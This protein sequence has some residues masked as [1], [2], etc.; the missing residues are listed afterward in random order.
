MIR[1]FEGAVVLPGRVLENGLTAVDGGRI[2]GVWDLETTPRPETQDPRNTTKVEKGFIAPG[3]IDQHCH[4]AG[5]AD[6]MDADPEAAAVITEIHA[7]HG[8]TAMLATTWTAPEEKIIRAIRAAK[9]APR[10]GARIVG[11]HVE[12]PFINAK[13][14][15]AQDERFIRPATVAE[16]DRILTEGA[17]EHAWHFTVA[18]EIPGNLDVVRY[19]VQRGAVVS[20]G[21]TDCTY[22]QLAEAAEAGVSHVT[23][24]YNAMRGLHHREPGTVG[25]AITMPAMTVELIADGIHVHP[26][27]MRVAVATRGVDRVLLVTDAM[28]AAGMPDGEYNAGGLIA[29]VKDGAVRLP[30]G[31]LAGSVL[32]MARAV[33]N[34]VHL[35]GVG[36]AEAVAMAT[37]NPARKQGL[38]HR[39]GSIAPGMDADLVLLDE[40]LNVMETI[41]EGT[42][43]YR[44]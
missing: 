10:R 2:A 24:L 4:G 11:F 23:H 14:K 41:V 22:A 33:R 7:R 8:T 27:A 30:S 44:R 15:G 21:H 31:T 12:G 18:P 26:A 17:P 40:Q 42:T 32:T 36:L 9:M 29:T 37:V 38:A 13:H 16:V 5:G 43:V 1:W 19:L 20:A 3:F 6:F 39:K 28:A 34:M 35:V 25:G